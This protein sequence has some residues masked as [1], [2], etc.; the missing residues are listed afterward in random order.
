MGTSDKR[1]GEITKREE[2]HL[3]TPDSALGFRARYPLRNLGFAARVVRCGCVLLLSLLSTG[4]AVAAPSS[5][6]AGQ[7]N[8]VLDRLSAELDA[9][10]F[11]DAGRKIRA[12]IEA[13]RSDYSAISDPKAL[14][15][16]LTSDMRSV[17]ND[18][19]LAVTFGEEL[20]VKRDLSSEERRAAHDF[21][22]RN[23]FGVRSARRLPANIGY[24]DLAYF[25]P[26]PDA[27]KQLAAAMQIV[28]GTDALI[29]DLRHNGGGSGDTAATLLSYFFADV[30]QLPSAVERRG[31]K[32]VERQHWTAAY[33]EGPKYLDRPV[34]VLT[35]VHTHSAAELCAYALKTMHRGEVV[36]EHTGGEATAASGE[37]DLGLGFSAFI[38][39][40]QIISPITKSNWMG[41][42][43]QPDIS[44]APGEE[45]TT[46]YVAAIKT[47]KLGPKDVQEERENALRDPQSALGEE[48]SGHQR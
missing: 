1:L 8:S 47:G 16:R 34:Y 14:A 9:Y 27:G 11:P 12:Q 7:V 43:V 45:L 36:G 39:N 6:S 44:T 42:G 28:A 22:L 40:G 26:D 35:S 25:S 5:L 31:R 23:G 46:A 2:A 15:S 18:R 17:G 38:A 37:V 20:A 10:V 19:H 24:V 4:A 33:V 29:L 3:R 41:S 32:T 30:A 48:L 21:D 13:H